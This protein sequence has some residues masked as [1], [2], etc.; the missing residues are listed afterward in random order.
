MDSSSIASNNIQGLQNKLFYLS[1]TGAT[2]GKS[3]SKNKIKGNFSDL[4]K[5]IM[6]I[7]QLGEKACLANAKKQVQK[8]RER[9]LESNRKVR[10]YLANLKLNSKST[11]KLNRLQKA[12][13]IVIQN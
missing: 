10:A 4:D 6:E 2:V 7:S 9:R 5:E 11:D 1:H 8:D 3:D 13:K 12:Q